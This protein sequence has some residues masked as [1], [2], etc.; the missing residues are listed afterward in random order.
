MAQDEIIIY[1]N[2]KQ[3]ED[4]QPHEEQEHE[5]D[6]L[7]QRFIHNDVKHSQIE[8]FLENREK[9]N[10]SSILQSG[11]DEVTSIVEFSNNSISLSCH[12][13]L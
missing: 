2:V 5:N 1:G 13:F 10:D 9:N 11:M 7:I 8:E 4:H 12:I 3:V 6:D